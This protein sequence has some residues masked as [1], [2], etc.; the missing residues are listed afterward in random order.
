MASPSNF[1]PVVGCAACGTPVFS[2]APLLPLSSR[3][4]VGAMI[5]GIPELYILNVAQ[6]LVLRLGRYISVPDI[7]AQLAPNSYMYSHG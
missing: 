4:A 5:R 6:G 2:W 1:V 7:E 3:A